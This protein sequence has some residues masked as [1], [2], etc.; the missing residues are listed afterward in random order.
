MKTLAAVEEPHVAR[1]GFGGV[2]LFD[3]QVHLNLAHALEFNFAGRARHMVDGHRLLT[4]VDDDDL[5]NATGHQSGQHLNIAGCRRQTC[6]RLAKTA[7]P[8]CADQS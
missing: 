7:Q 2:E 4:R 6:H 5:L 8:R 3:G 1:E